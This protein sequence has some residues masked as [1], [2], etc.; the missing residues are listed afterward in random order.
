MTNCPNCGAPLNPKSPVCLYC[1][2]VNEDYDNSDD[3]EIVRN[4]WGETHRISL[5]GQDERFGFANIVEPLD[6]RNAFF[7]NQTQNAH[8]TAE[9]TD[10]MARLCQNAFPYQPAPV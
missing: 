9:E 4:I 3:C 2:T 5:R 6:T 8:F 1:G 7:I 10:Q